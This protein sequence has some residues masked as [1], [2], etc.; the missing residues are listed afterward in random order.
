MSEF[1]Q[2]ELSGDVAILRI[3]DGKANALDPAIIDALHTCLDR[4]IERPGCD[5]KN[6]AST[7]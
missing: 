2:Y 1:V 6:R 4:A 3:D 5:A 7:S